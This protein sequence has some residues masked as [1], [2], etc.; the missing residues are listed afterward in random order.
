MDGWTANEDR[1]MAEYRGE[2]MYDAPDLEQD[3]SP[4]DNDLMDEEAV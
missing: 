1:Y 2:T 3:D 4:V